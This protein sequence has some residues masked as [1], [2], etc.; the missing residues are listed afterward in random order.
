[1]TDM[2]GGGDRDGLGSGDSW[3]KTNVMEDDGLFAK[4]RD[5]VQWSEMR[6][7]GGAVP[8]LVCMQG[9]YDVDDHGSIVFEPV[10]RHPAD[11]QPP[12]HA[13]TPTVDA[14]R[15]R[16]SETLG[17][18]L[19]H[20]IIQW[21]RGGADFISEHSDKTLD[22]ARGTVI[23]NYSAG[24]T[25]LLVLRDKKGLKEQRQAATCAPP[26]R[27]AQRVELPNN[28]LFV[29]G[30]DTNLRMTHEIR[31]DRRLD[32][33]KREDEMA[34]DAQRISITFRHI[35]TFQRH[36]DGK[37]FGQGA[38]HKTEVELDQSLQ[39]P[40]AAHAAADPAEVTRETDDMIAM[41]GAENQDPHFDWDACYGRGF[42]VMNMKSASSTDAV[43]E[44]AAGAIRAVA[45]AAGAAEEAQ[46][47]KDEPRCA[48]SEISD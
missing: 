15:L 36:S 9:T 40:E 13:W 6:H 3:L 33:D 27:N 29:L 46:E 4:L 32:H 1:M 14:I 39:V 22:I 31:Q 42:S 25:R 11:E 26:G 45:T 8:R 20:A 37:L 12:M 23:T 19:N 16:V 34:F 47:E 18:P 41:F 21:Y 7:K 38:V 44:L 30:W 2:E 5:E 35:A 17:Q 28:S 24:A 43:P 10:Y 48:S